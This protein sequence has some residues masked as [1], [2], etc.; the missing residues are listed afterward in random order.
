[1]TEGTRLRGEALH[2]IAGFTRAGIA[3]LRDASG[4]ELESSGLEDQVTLRFAIYLPVFLIALL[5]IAL[6]DALLSVT[7]REIERVMINVAYLVGL[8]GFKGCS[9]IYQWVWTARHNFCRYFPLRISP[10]WL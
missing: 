6:V 10:Q 1:M 8:R 3:F 4:H 9:Y 7:R 5:A 2:R